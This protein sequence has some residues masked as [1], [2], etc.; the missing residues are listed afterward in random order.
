MAESL[1][2]LQFQSHLGV[3]LFIDLSGAWY[4]FSNEYWLPISVTILAG[5][6][7]TETK[8]PKL[9]SYWFEGKKRFLP[10]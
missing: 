10:S 4:L 2:E 1:A 6:L 5:S 7:F 8:S 3:I 9:L